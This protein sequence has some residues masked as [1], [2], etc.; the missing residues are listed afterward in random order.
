M[1]GLVNVNEQ[2]SA[3]Y[4]SLPTYASLKGSTMSPNTPVK[5]LN[6]NDAP[7]RT[8]L[9]GF[10]S[11]LL[12]PNQSDPKLLGRGYYTISSAYGEEPTS[13]YTARGCAM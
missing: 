3:F 5:V 13:L 8:F 12:N 2:S 6:Q 4:S 7:M 11:G 9:S 10:D 1:S